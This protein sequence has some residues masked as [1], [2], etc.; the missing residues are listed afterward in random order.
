MHMYFSNCLPLAH[1]VNPALCIVTV[2]TG[3]IVCAIQR[4][5]GPTLRLPVS[6]VGNLGLMAFGLYLCQIQQPLA[7]LGLV[8]GHLTMSEF[9]PKTGK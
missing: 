7:A 1:Y 6:L 2:L 3:F 4:K 8:V 9:A 5:V